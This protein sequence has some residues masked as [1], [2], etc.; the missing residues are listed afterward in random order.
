MELCPEACLYAFVHDIA[1]RAPTT[2]A[3]LQTRDTLHGMALTVGLRFNKDKTEV[4]RWAKD[5][6]LDPITWHHHG[7]I[8]ERQYPSFVFKFR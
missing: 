2:E 1:V 3:L 4:Y 6:N 7:T 8:C 5:Y